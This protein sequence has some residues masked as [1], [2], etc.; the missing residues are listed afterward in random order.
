MPLA[1]NSLR[2]AKADVRG[3]AN[4]PHKARARGEPRPRATDSALPN[5][6]SMLAQC[7]VADAR[8]DTCVYG[9]AL[10]VI[11]NAITIGLKQR[12]EA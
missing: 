9:S 10:E 4:R 7:Q 12:Q 11:G 1:R 5:A 6:R 3:R 2:L 8:L